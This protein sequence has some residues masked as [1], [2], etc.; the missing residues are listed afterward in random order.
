MKHDEKAG[1]WLAPRLRAA[2]GIFLFFFCAAFAGVGSTVAFV[3]PTRPRAA[4]AAA[5]I[6]AMAVAVATVRF[7]GRA[8]PAVFA[9]GALNGL[10]ILAEG[11]ALNSPS[12]PVS[13]LLGILLTL[14][15]V[16]AAALTAFANRRQI[17]LVERFSF[18]GIFV[19]FALL[20]SSFDMQAVAMIGSL[21]FAGL[22]LLV[23]FVSDHTRHPT[24]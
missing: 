14:A 11:H 9:C 17:K 5:M 24:I 12:V 7:W 20:F 2:F 22:P 21:C 19:C 13:R 18:V 15:M 10:T 16:A 23:A 6:A 8:L 4:G 3:D 1:G